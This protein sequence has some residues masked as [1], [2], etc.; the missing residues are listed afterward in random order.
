MDCFHF[1]L[2]MEH[3][4]WVFSVGLENRDMTTEL[5]CRLSAVNPRAQQILKLLALALMIADHVHLV[6]FNRNLEWLYWLSRLVFPLFA[7]IA[8]QNLEHYH[9]NPHRYISRL[10]VWG[11][12]AQPAYWFCFHA[13][14][15]NVLFTL[16]S[17][18]CLY[19]VLETLRVRGFH[20]ILRYGIAMLVAFSLPFLEFGWSGVLAI[21][22]FATVMRRGAWW[23]W[24]AVL[25][26]AFGIVNFAAPWPIPLTAI[27]LWAF[28]ARW[29]LLDPKA[30]PDGPGSLLD[31]KAA[32]DGP[33]AHRMAPGG[34]FA[35]GSLDNARA[36]K[37]IQWAFYAIYPIHL[38]VIAVTF[39]LF[40]T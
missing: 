32:P 1:L 37:W 23:D 35:P 8:A 16:A 20:A 36:P 29:K 10:L 19:S 15:L 38:T 2:E 4:H 24:L 18:V 30:A 27:A 12:I 9:A 14:Q 6:F 31:P 7:L 11:L 25:V 28:A 17:S 22:V 39:V 34:P 21:P 13:P 3:P 5:T 33:L 26:L 40:K